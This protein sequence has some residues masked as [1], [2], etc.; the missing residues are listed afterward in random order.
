[1]TTDNRNRHIPIEDLS[2]YADGEVLTTSQRTAIEAHLASC[3]LCRDE[4]ESLQAVSSLLAD[5]PEPAIPRS[6]RLTPS[7]VASEDIAAAQPISI[8]PWIVRNQSKFRWAGLAAAVLLVMV[9]TADLFSDTSTDDSADFTLTQDSVEEIAPAEDAPAESP[10]IM[11]VEEA[12][13][14][15]AADSEMDMDESAESAPEDGAVPESDAD[16]EDRTAV[17]PA[18]GEESA[19]EDSDHPV[20]PAVPGD[21]LAAVETASEPDDG[22]SLLQWTGVVLAILAVSLLIVGFVLP[23]AWSTSRTT[24]R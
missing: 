23:Y 21:D 3:Q 24:R 14:E 13:E 8:E 10:G 15:S 2:A 16:Q 4:L 18:P 7:D 19:V 12:E 20:A 17:D 22:L 11:S 5:L 6:F 1:M 9:I